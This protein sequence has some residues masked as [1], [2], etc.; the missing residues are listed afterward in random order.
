MTKIMA[1]HANSQTAI[2]R[3]LGAAASVSPAAGLVIAVRRDTCQ[4]ALP[5]C[6]SR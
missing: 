6:P 3:R 5:N 1:Q 2:G 4:K